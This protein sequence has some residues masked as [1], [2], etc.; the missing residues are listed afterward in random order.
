MENSKKFNFYRLNI[1]KCYI[2]PYL[3]HIESFHQIDYIDIIFK[4]IILALFYTRIH[5][6]LTDH[7]IMI[8]YDEYKCLSKWKIIISR[9]N[10]ISR[11]IKFYFLFEEHWNVLIQSNIK[12][13]KMLGWPQKVTLLFKNR[14][15]FYWNLLVLRYIRELGPIRDDLFEIYLYAWCFVQNR[16][17]RGVSW[18]QTV[19]DIFD[20]FQWLF[21]LT[22]EKFW[23]T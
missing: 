14:E 17:R 23:K 12:S 8:I 3:N 22:L 5:K 7:N 2:D 9:N 20:T 10:I 11:L 6:F 13:R 1:V 16:K 4:F 15:V 18:I 19:D 21:E